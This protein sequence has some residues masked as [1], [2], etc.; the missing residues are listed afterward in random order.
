MKTELDQPVFLR[1]LIFSFY[2]AS[3]PTPE[4]VW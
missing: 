3:L 4:A 1:A 2:L